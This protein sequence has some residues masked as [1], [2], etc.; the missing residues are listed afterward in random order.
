MDIAVARQKH[1]RQLQANGRSQHTIDQYRRHALLLERWMVAS[2]YGTD[3]EVL[4]PEVLAEFLTA[5]T[6]TTRQDG[7]P[8]VAATM[9]ALRSSM[10]GFC[11]Y[12]RESGMLRENPARL[13][14]MAQCSPRPP[15]GLSPDNQRKLLDTL[16]REDG[17]RD[18]AL[19]HL[20]LATGIRLAS[21]LAVTVEDIDLGRGELYLRCTKGNRPQ[22]I[23]LG[24]RIRG[25]LTEYLKGVDG[26]LLFPGSSAASLSGRH[27]RRL[28]RHWCERAGVP[29]IGPH[30][31]RH[32]FAAELYRKTRDVL[33]VKAALGHRSLGSTLVYASCS[34]D[35]L[36]AALA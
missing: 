6:V 17:G 30:G 28:L 26:A 18:H 23:Y 32:S 31:L 13:L 9:N 5:P 10:R 27:A 7:R 2:G 21:A 36:R 16:E 1:T 33:L 24:E 4:C 25:H 34:P 15:R 14:R 11:Q 22:I 29:I 12:L 8:K 20:M 3:L 19:F 35:S